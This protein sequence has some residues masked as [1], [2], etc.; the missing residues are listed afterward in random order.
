MSIALYN[1]FLSAAIKHGISLYLLMA[2][3]SVESGLDV[4]AVN[5]N[6][7]IGSRASYG[8]CQVQYRTARHLGMK[9][10]HHCEE[11]NVKKCKLMK[12][13]INI[14]YAARYLV[15]QLVRYRFDEAKALSAY[16]AGSYSTKNPQYVHKVVKRM[17]HMYEH[18][19]SIR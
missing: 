8:I 16:N 19:I 4:K 14:D 9:E 17:Q 6:D 3:C 2:V 1:I 18:G 13:E 15:R 5:L 10:S 7:G 11:K 12:P